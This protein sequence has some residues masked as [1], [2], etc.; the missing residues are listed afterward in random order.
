MKTDNL[1][2]MDNLPQ[3]ASKNCRAKRIKRVLLT[4]KEKVQPAIAR[5]QRTCK[6]EK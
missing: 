4:T 3:N 2:A 6:K 1:V 5:N